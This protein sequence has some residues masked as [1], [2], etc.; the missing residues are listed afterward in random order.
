MFENI[1]TQA[2]KLVNLTKKIS[3]S[4]HTK[5]VAVTS[6]KGG[7]GKSTLTSNIAYLLSKKGL[8]V[9][10][11]DADIGLANMQV[12]F[13]VKPAATFFDY[14]E[15]T[16]SIE[17]ILTNTSYNNITLIAGKSGYQYTNVNNSM[18]FSSVVNEIVGL[19]RFDILL[20][21]T[22]AGLNSYVQEFLE[23]TDN[24][25]AV[26]TTDPSALTDV[27]A[28]MKMLSIKKEKLMLCFNHTLKYETGKTITKSIKELAI[29]NKLNRNFM[30][31]YIG[32]V[33][34]SR[35]ISSTSRLRKLFSHEFGGDLVTN[36][37]D[38]IADNLIEEIKVAGKCS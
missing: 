31:K 10:I 23:L 15:G 22:G 18:V 35:G 34:E 17:N 33:K 25:I 28:L 37:M 13:N 26:T 16:A 9:G 11:L 36:Q 7:V 30:V 1:S 32:N 6:G 21:D 4:N 5:V 2:N 20:I 19:K 3:N 24:I 8:K 14:F 27:Y 38:L 12:M 29:K